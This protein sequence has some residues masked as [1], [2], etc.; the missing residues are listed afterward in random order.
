M[1]GKRGND[2]ST[3]IVWEYV[4]SSKLNRAWTGAVR[5]DKHCSEI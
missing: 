1:L 4:S 3:Q 5:K 2:G